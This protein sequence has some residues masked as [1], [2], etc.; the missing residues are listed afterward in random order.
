MNET[1]RARAAARWMLTL[2][3]PL[4]SLEDRFDIEQDMG[5]AVANHPR[6]GAAWFAG[7]LYEVAATL[8]AGDPWLELSVRLD[9]A[10]AGR[11]HVSDP[12][13]PGSAGE[14]TVPGASGRVPSKT[15][16]V[17]PSGNPFGTW[18]S[19]ADMVPGLDTV[20]PDEDRAL[21]AVA[22]PMDPTAAALLGLAASREDGDPDRVARALGRLH[23]ALRAED[24]LGDGPARWM[25]LV[26]QALRWLV[27]RR[28]AYVVSEDTFIPALGYAWC[29][30]AE[31]AAPARGQG[32][33]LAE[34][35]TNWPSGLIPPGQY[36]M[37][38]LSD[39]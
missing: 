15:G 10:L 2:V 7:M 8:P 13:E 9:Y 35:A 19:L 37:F 18:E 4:L 34:L 32:R 39:L 26:G 5:R 21:V 28:L 38:R 33:T 11:A 30:S 16:A 24:P 1:E 27:R 3:E 22:T 6:W 25:V 17:L 14:E 36:E 23:V 20:G 29:H 31:Q 12:V